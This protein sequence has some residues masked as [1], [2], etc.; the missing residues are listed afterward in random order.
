MCNRRYIHFGYCTNTIE[1]E[2]VALTENKY[3]YLFGQVPKYLIVMAQPLMFFKKKLVQTGKQ[4]T[5]LLTNIS[6]VYCTHRYIT[7]QYKR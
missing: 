2:N 6:F 4:K 7:K 5:C 1:P 3:T